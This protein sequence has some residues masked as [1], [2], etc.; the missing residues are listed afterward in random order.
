MESFES[1]IDKTLE[2][3]KTMGSESLGEFDVKKG[4]L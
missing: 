3:K 1:K 4:S 2:M